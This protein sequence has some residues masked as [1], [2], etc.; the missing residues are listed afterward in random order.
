MTYA[1]E[2]QYLVD[3][4][5][6]LVERN[7]AEHRRIADLLR[8]ATPSV[9]RAEQVEWTSRAR[10]GYEARLRDVHGLV[11]GLA[12]GYDAAS[13]ALLGYADALET[14]QAQRRTGREYEQELAALCDRARFGS[15]DEPMRRWE[16]LR[17]TTGLLDWMSD[18]FSDPDAVRE[19]AEDRY[20]RTSAAFAQAL[21]TEQE[22]RGRCVA[23][24]K[25][26]TARVPEFRTGFKDAAALV[27]RIGR[28]GVL[29]GEAAEAAHDPLTRLAG[30]GVKAD[31]A[32]TVG[33]RAAVSPALTRI[34][35]LLA[36]LPEGAGNNYWLPSDSDDSRRRWIAANRPLLRA[37]AA[38]SGLPV[39]MLAGIAWQE[40]EGDP[41][42]VDD[43]AYHVRRLGSDA[44]ADKT[45][46]GPLSI[47]VRRAAE[48]LGYDPAH[49][50]EAQRHEVVSAAREPGQNIFITARYLAQLKAESGFAA[51]EPGRMTEDQYQELAARYNG[52]PYWESEH[53]QAYGRSFRERRT[54]VKEALAG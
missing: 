33:P 12:E 41:A 17:E 40:V 7:A 42:V 39:D 23:A 30:T 3:C 34:R 14:A 31:T 26:A 50:T 9:R 52:G 45:S 15:G 20:A 49:L 54:L 36:D 6:A 44:A 38:E 16:D 28:L 18:L 8:S 2:V 27:E 24:L 25:A 19:Q 1:A 10:A 43:I 35:S 32:P 47:Q 29:D 53:A 11:D 46:V 5:P 37:A 13:R 48:V 21:R 4:N 22:A 51:V